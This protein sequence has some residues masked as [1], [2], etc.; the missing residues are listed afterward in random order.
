MINGGKVQYNG[1]KAKSS[2]VVDIGAQI[3]LRQGSDEKQVQVMALSEHR[4]GASIA[5]TL[6]EELPESIAKREANAE[7]RRLNIL[8]NPSPEG[9]PD[10]K[11]RRQIKKFTTSEY[12][13]NEKW[14]E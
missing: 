4:Q 12:R 10:K 8:A 13:G 3:K 11:Q 7:A 1:Q 6:Y 14:G 2:R 5:Q 9:K